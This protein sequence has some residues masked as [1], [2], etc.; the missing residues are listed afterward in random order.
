MASRRPKCIRT[1]GAQIFRSGIARFQ[2]HK[3]ADRQHYNTR[4]YL[5]EFSP[6]AFHPLNR[7]HALKKLADRSNLPRHELDPATSAQ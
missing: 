7:T 1:C 5:V 4:Q 6:H 3:I 2:G